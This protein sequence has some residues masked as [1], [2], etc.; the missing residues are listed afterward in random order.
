MLIAE[1][2]IKILNLIQDSG[3]VQVEELAQE[4]DVSPMTIRRDLEKLRKDGLVERCHGGAVSKMEINYAE[5]RIQNRDQKEQ[6]AKKCMEFIKAGTTVFLDAGTT[7][8]EIARRMVDMENMTVVTNDLEIALLMKNSKAD[9][10]LCG[11]YV[12]KSTGSTFGYYATQMMKDFRFDAG[13]FGAAVIN[14]EF[15][16]L[17]PTIDKAFLKRLVAEQCQQSYLVVDDSKFNRQGMNRIN[18]LADY[19]GIIT[20]HKFKESEHILL[21]K[22][23]ARIITVTDH[24]NSIE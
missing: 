18:S 1:R 10:I 5:K 7:T 2:Q 23:G 12:Q 24:D 21:R 17:T 3:S 6:I 4:L 11:G 14:E 16:V 22:M 15:Q 20:D 13:F 8:Y 9:L 19:A